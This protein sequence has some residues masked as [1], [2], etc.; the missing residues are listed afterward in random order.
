MLNFKGWEKIKA[1]NKTTTLKHEKGHEMTLAHK[2]LPKIQQEALKRLKFADGGK[3]Q[4]YADKGIVDGSD[5]SDS[6]KDSQSPSVVINTGTPPAM[7]SAPMPP[8]PS[9]P[10]VPAAPAMQFGQGEMSAPGVAQNALAGAKL[11]SQI[12]ASQTAA[13]IPS[14]E[15]FIKNQEAL[16]KSQADNA[17]RLNETHEYFRDY[18]NGTTINPK[19]GQEDPSTKLKENAYLENMGAGTK[20]VK[21]IGLLF[22]GAG[23]GLTGGSNLAYD[24]LNKQIDRNIDA[25]KERWQQQKTVWGAAREMF[26]DNNVA[27]QLARAHQ[28]QLIND[29]AKLIS[30]QHGTPQAA[31]DYMKAASVLVPATN[32]ALIKA[33]GALKNLKGNL[34]PGVSSQK[35]TV[36]E[37]NSANNEPLK[38]NKEALN[39]Y[40]GIQGSEASQSN[41]DVLKP[42][43]YA[44]SPILGSHAKERL[45]ELRYIPKAKDN[46]KDIQDSY[47]AGL[48]ADTILGQLHEVHQKIAANVR[49]PSYSY[50]RRHNPLGGV[51][52]IGE[53][54]SHSLLQPTTDTPVNRDFESNRTRIVAD[55]ANAVGPNVSASEIERMVNDNLPEKDDSPKAIAQK[56]RNIRIFIKNKVNKGLINTWDLDK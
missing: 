13:Q 49:D 34:P 46:I 29:K 15:E 41:E 40:P 36:P 11:Q 35:Q 32:D 25:Q 17:A 31:A 33:S 14:Q 2:K 4:G 22:S 19:T 12:Q 54:L 47:N 20:M 26:G 27:D 44:D 52:V 30:L 18:T 28:L 55:I 24:F 45:D 51:P 6:M 56:E 3:T 48:Q 7:Q 37:A 9:V 8:K 23:S 53:A 10:S 39:N 5:S 43:K 21:A 38:I 16:N 1:D 42:D 50:L